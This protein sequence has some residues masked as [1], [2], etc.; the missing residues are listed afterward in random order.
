MQ[1]SQS[2]SL[3][4]STTQAT[5]QYNSRFSRTPQ[6]LTSLSL[7]LARL[8]ES[9]SALSC[10]NST[11]NLH[12]STTSPHNSSSTTHQQ[13]FNQSFFKDTAMAH[14][15]ACPRTSCSTH[16]HSLESPPSRSSQ[17]RTTRESQSSTS[18]EFQT[19][20]EMKSASPRIK[21][22]FSQMRRQGTWRAS[23][24]SRGRSTRSTSLCIL[25]TCS[26]R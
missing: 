1:T 24:L 6:E 20:T 4:S 25:E 7:Q 23:L 12:D 22:S 18:G 21:R 19:N 10:L 13:T 26:I 9:H 16:L 5:H 11:Q 14:L 17:S 2:T 15:S 3:S 8:K